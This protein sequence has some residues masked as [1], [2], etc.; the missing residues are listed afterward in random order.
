M[1]D[2]EACYKND[3]TPWDK[4]MAAPP[5]VELVDRYGSVVFCVGPVLV[6]GCGLGYDVRWLA[7][8]GIPAHGVDIS[9]TAVAKAISMTTGHG[10]SFE[11][12]D[13]LDPAWRVGR[14]YA[15]IWEHTCF[16]AIDPAQRDAYARSAADILETGGI[17]A[18]VFYLTP[19]DPGEDETSGPP[20]KVTV[21]ELDAGFSPWFQRID[22]WVPSYCYPGREG[23]EWIGI[24]RKLPHLPVV[25]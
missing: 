10:A 6:P 23:R 15:A 12:G 4:G 16:C 20:F 5:L 18:G 2:W 7:D 1:R 14:Q 3:E 24:F 19:H 9:E 21:E 13:F 17:L 11:H 25:G 22:G 8:F